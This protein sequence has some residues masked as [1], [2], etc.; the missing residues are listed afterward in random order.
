MANAAS[1]LLTGKG[2]EDL[3]DPCPGRRR[4]RER[5]GCRTTY[6]CK[7]L[8]GQRTQRRGLRRA[9]AGIRA[10]VETIYSNPGVRDG[11]RG[12]LEDRKRSRRQKKEDKRVRKIENSTT[13]RC[14]R[15]AEGKR[16]YRRSKKWNAMA[17]N[18]E[19]NMAEQRKKRKEDTWIGTWNVQKAAVRTDGGGSCHRSL[20]AANMA[21]HQ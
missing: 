18:N 3:T 1:H 11:K 7:Q 6:L 16:K 13:E 20:S 8:T 17:R 19:S 10:K 14:N 5:G 4:R 21:R 15:D 12:S 9:M 2:K